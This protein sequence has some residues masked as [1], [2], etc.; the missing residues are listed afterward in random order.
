MESE[1]TFIS[2]V[3]TKQNRVPYSGIFI[4]DENDW[5]AKLTDTKI[6]QGD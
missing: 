4:N 5:I 1:N 3:T 2:T 6:K